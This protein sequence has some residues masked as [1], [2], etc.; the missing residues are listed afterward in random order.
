M[1]RLRDKRI[2]A[3]RFG[4]VA[5]AIAL[6]GCFATSSSAL[7]GPDELK[8]GSVVM[9][10]QNG[11]GL[12]LSP[13]SLNLPIAGGAVDPISGAGTVE[14]SGAI[15]V[16]R[17][18]SKTKVKITELTFG[19]NGGQGSIAAKVG[20]KKVKRF[21]LLS[22]G[23][24]ARDGWGAK[25]TGV[26]AKLGSKGAK[27]LQT[28]F[29]PKKNGRASAAG[30]VKGGQTLGTVSATTDPKTVEVKPGGTLV[31]NADMGFANKLIAHCVNGL[32]PNGVDAIPPATKNGL[33]EFDF[34][35]T[36]GNISPDF[37]AGRVTSAGG[38]TISKNTGLNTILFSCDQGPPV[39]TTVTSTE[40]EDQ[41]ELQVLASY[42]VLPTGPVGIGALG[43]FDLS[44]ASTK[45]ADVGT[46]QITITDAPVHLD[47]LT[48]FILNQVLP[49]ESS[50]PSN[51]FAPG[52]LL[53]TMSLNVSTH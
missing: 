41:F 46:K 23:T 7:A 31:F 33:T 44:A 9:Q 35:V 4:T 6:I 52:D 25:I 45:S 18:K 53:G 15:K 11:R 48:A 21:A 39:G 40:F 10:L 13:K 32:L 30:G 3:G 50:S 2:R 26:T 5:A 19:A 12:K 1:S 34:P 51:D 29:S 17:G 14:T 36:G 16:K 22:G 24:V 27:A 8:G 42:T 47:G 37:T 28:A 20:K 43:Q 38:Q 49:N